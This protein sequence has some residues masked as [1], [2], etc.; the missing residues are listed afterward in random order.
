MVNLLELLRPVLKYITILEGDSPSIGLTV[1]AYAELKTHFTT[2]LPK[3]AM[4]KKEEKQVLDKLKDRKQFCLK[5]VHH[6]ANLLDPCYTGR[7]LSEEEVVDACEYI[8]KMFNCYNVSGD[9]LAD[10]ANYT[11]K[12]GLWNMEFV[13][14]SAKEVSPVVWWKGIC[15]T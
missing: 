13:W 7:N 12:E 11:A 2:Y 15:S 4:S 6:A 9:V 3:S 8:C 1:E 10:I 5:T 14:K